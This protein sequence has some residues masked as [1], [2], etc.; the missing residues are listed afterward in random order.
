M[1]PIH[2]SDSQLNALASF[3][4]KLNEK[5]AA[6]MESSPQFAVE[7]AMIYQQNKCG[8]CHQVNGAGV[9]MGPT[10]NGVGQR[11][12]REWIEQHF[13]EPQKLSPGTVMPPYRFSTREMDRIT[14]YMLAI[15]AV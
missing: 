15:P 14:S 7:G 10:L 5:N 2:L 12:S 13:R 1:P 3:L 4:L 9:K 8:A 6:A 11:R